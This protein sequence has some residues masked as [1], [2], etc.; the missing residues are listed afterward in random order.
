M[1]NELVVDGFDEEDFTDLQHILTNYVNI[2]VKDANYMLRT[3]HLLGK[4]ESVLNMLKSSSEE[5]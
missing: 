1:T 2:P 3:L 4:V 5:V